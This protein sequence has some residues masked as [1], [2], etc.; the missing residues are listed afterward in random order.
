MEGLYRGV[1]YY[2]CG[3][4]YLESPQALARRDGAAEFLG[5]EIWIGKNERHRHIV[6]DQI[7][8]VVC[9]LQLVPIHRLQPSS[10]LLR[11]GGALHDAM[12]VGSLESH[13]IALVESAYVCASE[14]SHLQLLDVRASLN[15]K[16]LQLCAATFRPDE[17]SGNR[18]VNDK[19]PRQS[20][21]IKSPARARRVL[22]RSHLAIS[23]TH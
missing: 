11:R 16:L 15:H 13:P 1:S 14:A 10:K 22:Q 17:I 4:H 5:F 20:P 21:Q 7:G 18:H 8:A 12:G 3:K 9:E 19:S 2:A 23:G 6:P